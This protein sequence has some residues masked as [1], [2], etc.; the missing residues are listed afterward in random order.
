MPRKN[1]APQRR[2]QI[3]SALFDC[4][5]D[6][7]HETVTIKDIARRANLHYGVIHY[8]FKS[9][10]EIVSEMADFIISK[11]ERLLLDRVQSAQ[12]PTEKIQVAIGFLVDEFIFNRRLNRV[13]Y[14][15]VQMAFERE[16]VREALRRQLR[17]Y[18]E[19]I[20]EVVKE[21]IANGEF[22]AR[23]SERTAA[24]I[25][26]VIEGMALQWVIDPKKLERSEVSAVIRETIERHLSP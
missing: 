8:Y 13:F 1:L 20:G 14:N 7:G 23:E 24:L 22:P 4:L 11:Y 5:A 25:V 15:L 10:D 2:R 12:S 16:A 26:A 17:V 9:K 6:C 3:V 18:R 21:G 19:H